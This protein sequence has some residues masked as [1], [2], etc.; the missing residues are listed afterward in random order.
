MLQR[1]LDRLPIQKIDRQ[2]PGEPI[3][4]EGRVIQPIAHVTGGYQTIDGA[5]S[6]FRWASLRIVPSEIIVREANGEERRILI[7]NPTRSTLLMFVI[8]GLSVAAG[9]VLIIA[10]H[11][12]FVVL[13]AR[14]GKGAEISA[15]SARLTEAA[16]E[17]ATSDSPPDASAEP[18]ASSETQQSPT[19][20]NTNS[21]ETTKEDSE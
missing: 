7:T 9:C 20:A 15:Q 4:V 8:A 13:R 1:V 21:S 10:M 5:T 19:D 17:Q 2:L 18:E 6:G 14:R 16:P 12:V 3:T 11:R